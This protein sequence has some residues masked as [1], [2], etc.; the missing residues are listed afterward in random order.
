MPLSPWRPNSATVQWAPERQRDVKA[1]NNPVDRAGLQKMIPAVDWNAMLAVNGLKDVQHFVVN[2]TTALRDG[3]KLLDTQPVD[4][5]KKYLAFHLASDYA[6]Y[7]PKAFDEASFAFNSKTLRGVEVQRDRWKRGVSLLND[8]IGEGVRPVVRGEV[9]PAGQQSQDG[10]TG[11]QSP[12][13]HGRAPQ[14]AGVD[15]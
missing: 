6:S 5:W 3:A 7:L 1:T 2:E 14:D 15:G 10:R 12:D 8:Q 4:V 11:R 9:L 13:R